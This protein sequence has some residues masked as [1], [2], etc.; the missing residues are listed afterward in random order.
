MNHNM[1]AFS[2]LENRGWVVCMSLD[3]MKSLAWKTLMNHNMMA[4]LLR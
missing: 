1:M 4:F 3:S 2:F